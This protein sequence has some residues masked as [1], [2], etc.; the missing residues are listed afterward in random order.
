MRARATL[1]SLTCLALVSGCALP[2]SAPEVP[3]PAL[4]VA[5]FDGVPGEPIQIEQDRV[6]Q[7]VAEAERA[8][9][10]GRTE[11][12]AGR[13]E[14]ARYSF[15]SAVDLLLQEPEGARGDSRLR[16]EFDSLLD[17]ISAL[18]LIALREGDGVT[19]ADSEP[20]AIDDLLAAAMFERPEPAATTAETVASDLERTPHDV[21]IPVNDRVLSYVELFQGNLRDFMQAGLDRSVRYLPMIQ[22]IFRDEGIPLDLAYVPLVE[23]AFKV[24]ALSRA[25]AR[26]MWQFMSGTAR[27]HGLEQ[28]WYLDERS[29]PEK[30]TRAAARYLKSLY[31]VFG[32]W[33]LAL[34]SYN[35]GP[36]RLQRAIRLSKQT[37][38]WAISGTSRY[39]PRETREYVPMIMA[40]MVIA[41]N[42]SLY[43]FEVTGAAP[44]AYERVTVPDALNL[45]IIAEWAGVSVEA[46]QELNPELRRLTT[47]AGEHELKV[48]VG[49]A[50]TIETRLATADPGLFVRFEYHAV[51]RG[52]TLSGI[53]RRYGMSVADLMQAN[54]LRTTRLQI[55]QTLVIPTRP[56]NALPTARPAATSR[57]ASA[58][59]ARNSGPL[60]YRV[61]RGDTLIGIAK[62]FATTVAELKRLNN[63]RN[64]RIVAGDRLTVRR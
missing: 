31:E 1:T 10:D 38:Y 44:L 49:T 50:P 17:R 14:A 16:T 24:T 12:Q 56:A 21:P 8:F 27:E 7:L 9:Q 5:A 30:A 18:E 36:G 59:P 63:L 33:P 28:N 52:E 23:S 3:S 2:T 42:P 26:G 20:A 4:P 22:D 45:K 29:D 48:P 62:Q 60:T 41:R 37:D 6:A 39:L 47:P 34:A 32:D 43:G 25:R 54:Q 64:D 46:L 61:R 19:E 15:D 40:A 58:A 13:I 51:R 57:P 35:A 53:A 11:L 55:N